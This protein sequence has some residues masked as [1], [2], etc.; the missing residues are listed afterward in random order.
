MKSIGSSKKGLLALFVALAMLGAACTPTQALT[1]GA[2]PAAGASASS[3]SGNA[4]QV[5]LAGTV[6]AMSAEAW[7]IN[8]T[9]TAVTAETEIKDTI[10]VGD[11]VQ[12][13][14]HVQPDGSLV[15][16]QVELDDGND[17]GN[18]NA[19][20]NENNNGN[21]NANVNENES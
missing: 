20:E 6:E 19:N 12:A 21:A 3:P 7:T 16:E 9:V 4:A 15:L 18:A 1:T 5:D 14:A 10:H 13:R 8:G 11:T 17:N 2:P